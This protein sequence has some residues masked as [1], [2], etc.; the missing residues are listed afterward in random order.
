MKQSEAKGKFSLKGRKLGNQFALAMVI[1]AICVI[2]SIVS[3]TFLTNRNIINIFRQISI[4]GII[5][6]GMTFVI[7]L[8]DIDLSVGSI[9]AVVS[10][11]TGRL[12]LNGWG[13]FG[14]CLVGLLVGIA[15]GFLNGL[16][17]AY[18]RFQPFV[19]TLAT[20][21]IGEGFA[22][23]FSDGRP[24]VITDAAFKQI[25][26]GSVAGIPIPVIILI[27][28]CAIGLV[29]LQST[30]FG[31]HVFAVGG[32]KSAAKLSGVRT[33]HVEVAVYVISGI[34]SALAAFILSAR[35]SSGQPTSGQGYELDAIAS[36]AIGGTSMNGGMGGLTGTILGF[37]LIGL[38]SNS[39]NLLNINS[40]Y[41]QMVKGVLIILA[42]LMDT[43]SKKNS[44]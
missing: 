28:V 39:M 34:C 1:L 35:I 41:Q 5:A 4:N 24:Y 2:M 42:V 31:R 44:K 3:P 23:A 15:Y 16:L 43:L 17:V 13:W 21:T 38:I 6:V 11:V 32:N 10:V 33:R 9:V 14:V 8:G 30:T 22:L 37:F 27:V 25:G 36:T 12:L 26:Q 19:A 20:V 18:L 7:L 29:I 40:F